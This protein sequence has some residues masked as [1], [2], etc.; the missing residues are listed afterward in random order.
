M[1][2]SFL[3]FKLLGKTFPYCAIIALAFNIIPLVLKLYTLIRIANPTRIDT[4]V[5]HEIKFNT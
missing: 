2:G 3:S 5:L 4:Q 1:H